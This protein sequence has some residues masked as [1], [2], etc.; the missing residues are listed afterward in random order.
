MKKSH[1][2]RTKKVYPYNNAGIFHEVPIDYLYK[3]EEKGKWLVGTSGLGAH[4]ATFVRI[5]TK[6]DM[7]TLR[8]KSVWI[9]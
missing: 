6:K 8:K 1:P 3:Y 2:I 7:K 5:A 9:D 4:A